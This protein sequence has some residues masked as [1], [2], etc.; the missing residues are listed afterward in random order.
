[1]LARMSALSSL[2]SLSIAPT[3]KRFSFALPSRR[4]NFVS[5]LVLGLA[6]N[7]RGL[8]MAWNFTSFSLAVLRGI[9]VIVFRHTPKRLRSKRGLHPDYCSNAQT[10]VSTATLLPNRMLPAGCSSRVLGL[11]FV[12]PAWLGLHQ[13]SCV[14][15]LGWPQPLGGRRVMAV[16]SFFRFPQ[17]P[18][19]FGVSRSVWL[20]LIF[21]QLVGKASGRF[22]RF[23]S[24]GR[25]LNSFR[26]VCLWVQ[27]RG[28][29][30]VCQWSLPVLVY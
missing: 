30:T 23:L 3:T 29:I 26:F 4:F 11:A 13:C 16:Q 20:R 1:M 14:A 24:L 21:S 19:L 22:H 5:V 12:I 6:G 28:K 18:G 10:Q 7:G 17:P 27:V 8:A 25:P 9:K 2:G 15:S